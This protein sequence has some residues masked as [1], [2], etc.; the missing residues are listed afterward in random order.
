M[1]RCRNDLYL[2]NH[3]RLRL[4]WRRWQTSPA[5]SRPSC[6]LRLFLDLNFL[7]PQALRHQAFNRTLLHQI[8]VRIC[9]LQ[10][11][12]HPR[13]VRRQIFTQHCHLSPREQS[14]RVQNR[15]CDSD[16]NRRCQPA[17]DS[18]LHHQHHRGI[19]QKCKYRRQYQSNEK[20]APKVE[21]RNR[22]S[23][24]DQCRP[25]VN[26]P[27]RDLRNCKE[28]QL[29]DCLWYRSSHIISAYNPI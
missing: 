21:Q 11:L 2:L 27:G 9:F 12:V 20:I 14:E 17:R 6:V 25:D 1:T 23:D 3:R 19:K 26:D 10:Q 22:G 13:R 4:C 24:G 8:K 16:H 29:R 18:Q 15:E 7:L 5:P 28:S